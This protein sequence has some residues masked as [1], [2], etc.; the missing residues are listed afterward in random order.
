MEAVGFSFNDFDFI[1]NAFQ[2]AGVDRVL[3][4]IQDP[5]LVP[6]QHFGKAGNRRVFQ[7]SCK[8]APVIEGLFRPRW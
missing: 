6:F 2:F 8:G 5:I 7:G 3:T 1:I 4:M